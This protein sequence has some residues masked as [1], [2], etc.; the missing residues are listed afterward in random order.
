MRIIDGVFIQL[1]CWAVFSVFIFGEFSFAQNCAVE[2]VNHYQVRASDTDEDISWELARHLAWVHPNCDGQNGLLVHIGGTFSNPS[3]TQ[4]FLE[5]AASMGFH[6]MSLKYP[7][8]VAAKSACGNSEDMNC[9]QKFRNEIIYG[10]DSSDEVEVD[11]TNSIV[12]RLQKLLAYLHQNYPNDQ[13]D[14]FLDKGEIVW[15]NTIVSGHS[16]GGVHAAFMAQMHEVKR[17]LMFASPNDYS[18]HFNQSA[19]WINQNFATPMERFFAFGNYFDEVVDFAEQFEVWESMNLLAIQDSVLVD[20][21]SPP[22]NN[23]QVL[24]TKIQLEGSSN[25]SNMIID[26]ILPLDEDNQPIFKD[27]WQYLLTLDAPTSVLQQSDNETTVYQHHPQ[28]LTIKLT[29]EIRQVKIYNINGQLID[30]TSPN[31]S[32]L[33]ILEGLHVKKGVYLINVTFKD[34]TL[35]MQK[36]IF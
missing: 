9:F 21:Q 2:G 19:P 23:A 30:A 22:Y 27:V 24:Y 8:N 18:A 17:V 31:S 7:N 6:V 33:V 20:G 15:K 35:S 13:W 29:K 28:G 3:N 14:L 34:Q 5:L 4:L 10:E 16:Q 11:S 36:V 26:N 32:N 1:K 12:N 25:H